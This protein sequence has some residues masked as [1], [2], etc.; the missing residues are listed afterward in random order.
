MTRNYEKSKLSFGR[1]YGQ[2]GCLDGILW[3][4]KVALKLV[5]LTKLTQFLLTPNL[6]THGL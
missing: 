5:F 2:L 1:P 3:K 4:P 6:M